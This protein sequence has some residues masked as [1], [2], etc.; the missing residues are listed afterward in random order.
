M[1][2]AAIVLEE[3]LQALKAR[4]AMLEKAL[5]D[6]ARNDN[7]RYEHH[8]RREWDRRFPAEDGGT[9]WLTPREIARRALGEPN[10]ATL[11]DALAQNAPT[12][13]TA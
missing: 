7:S 12:R 1:T 13:E 3:E 2:R 11:A 6:A 4:V 8:Q 10:L 9:I 5:R